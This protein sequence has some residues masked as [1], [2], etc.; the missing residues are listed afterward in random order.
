[1]EAKG[2]PEQLKD[3]PAGEAVIQDLVNKFS[4]W[5][6][7]F[8][9]MVAEGQQLALRK[10]SKATEITPYLEKTQVR[11]EAFTDFLAYAKKFSKMAPKPKAKGEP[12]KKAGKK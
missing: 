9:T 8:E 2:W 7:E 1:M 12:K 3:S 10:D 5:A 11:R 4:N 6:L